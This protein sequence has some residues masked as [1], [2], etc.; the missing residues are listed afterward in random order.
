MMHPLPSVRAHRALLLLIAAW[1]GATAAAGDA[2]G[3][4]TTIPAE[5]DPNRHQEFLAIAKAGGVDLLFLGDSITDGWRGNGQ[6]VWNKY[7]APL[8]AANFGIGGDQVQ[9]V[10]WRLRHG[11][12]DGIQPKLVVLMIGTNNGGDSVDDVALGIKTLLVEIHSHS[13]KSKV[14]LL[15]IFPR[16]EHPD[17]AREKNDNV[18]KQI[19]K[20]AT[21][22]EGR[23]I[24]YLDIGSRFLA[25]D[26][27]LPKDIM[28]DSLHPNEKGYQ[29]W[30]EATIDT[31]K[32]MMQDEPMK[33]VPSFSPPSAIQ[34][35]AR[36]EDTIANGKVG[37]GA[38]ALEKL[39]EDKDAK[40]ADAAKASLA[41]VQTWKAQVDA[42]L[43][44]LKDAGDVFV[45]GELAASLAAGYAGSDEGKAY[46]EQASA[47]K[48]D[49]AFPAGK[50]FQKLNEFPAEARR[51]PRFAKMVEAFVKKYPAGYYAQQAQ[52][53]LPAK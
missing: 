20:F 40:T 43:A 46:Q 23:R 47:L 25:A 9:H 14:L 12:L 41:T 27:T 48:K 32:Q 7:W 17:G 1:L 16:S 4:N 18:N 24:V 22:A 33:P 11:E 21:F 3:P 37:I 38:K 53:L 50:E 36:L 8:K 28:P 10:L 39:V 52:A 42:E 19:A 51:D 26:G 44:K 13:P 35:V 15:G 30:A 29:I 6:N 49:P 34:R 45:A 5:K 31:V 2:G